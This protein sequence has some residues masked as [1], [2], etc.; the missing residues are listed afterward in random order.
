[1]ADAP[2]S[3]H[4]KGKGKS[5][6]AVIAVAVIAVA[7]GVYLYRSPQEDGA[8][9]VIVRIAHALGRLVGY[10]DRARKPIEV[11]IRE[12]ENGDE[13]TRAQTITL[14][15]DHLTEPAEFVRVFP[16]LIRATKDESEMVRNSVLPVLGSLIRRF[17]TD[18]SGTDGRKFEE[19]LAALL[20]DSSPILRASAARFLRTLAAIRKLDAPPPQLVACL[21]DESEEVR[22]AAAESLVE[23]SQGPEVLLPIAAATPADRKPDR[24]QRIHADS[25]E[26]AVPARGL[27]AL[28]RGVVERQ[29]ARVCQR[30]HGDQ[31]HG[32]R[33]ETS[34]ARRHGVTSQ[35]A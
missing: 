13:V 31:P 16:Y 6:V 33:R 28:D 11:M 10:R 20:N 1:M 18:G 27:T 26:P 30:G 8:R 32:A 35:G 7:I 23:Y 29:H 17:G 25:L 22:A 14:L 21:D 4:G 19:S 12:I 34:A 24:V 5:W 15:H 2:D 9:T 3:N